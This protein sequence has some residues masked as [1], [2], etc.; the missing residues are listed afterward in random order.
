MVARAHTYAEAGVDIDAGIALVEAIKPI[1]RSTRRKGADTAL[2]GFAASFIVG[3]A[4]YDNPV[5]FAAADGV[6]SK[7]L[8]AIATGK[9]DTIGIDLVA[10]CVND[11]VVH[12]A[13][14]LFFLDYFATGKLDVASAKEI[15]GGIVKGCQHAGCALVGGETAEMPGMYMAGD[16][17]LA[18][19]V[20]GMAERDQVVTGITVNIGDVILGLASSGLHANGFSLVRRIMSDL[21]MQYSDTAPFTTDQKSLGE[22][23]LTP[24]RIYVDSCLEVVRKGRVKALAHITGGGLPDN[25]ARVLPDNLAAII[26][27]STWPKPPVFKWLAKI[28]NISPTEM[29]RTFNCGIGMVVIVSPEDV[30]HVKK[31]LIEKGEKVYRIGTIDRKDETYQA[32]IN[33]LDVI[34]DLEP[35]SSLAS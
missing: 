24:T 23:F 20:V 26:D 4:G 5:L 27:A 13:E 2:R 25:I 35:S 15:I 3:D 8:I 34:W 12:G 14:P 11:V 18:G 28:G 21:E 6:G 17:D 32:K 19:F 30:N 29:T 16:Y 1:V 33:N 31:L 7:L 10:M 22:I 9:H